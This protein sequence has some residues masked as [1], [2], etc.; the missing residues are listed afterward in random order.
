MNVAIYSDTSFAT[1]KIHEEKRKT[2]Q[3]ERLLSMKQKVLVILQICRYRCQSKPNLHVNTVKSAN[4]GAR[5]MQ[6]V[7]LTAERMRT[8]VLL[9]EAERLP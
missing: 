8:M 6:F 7:R 9:C 4:N 1:R 5:L 3:L 2:C